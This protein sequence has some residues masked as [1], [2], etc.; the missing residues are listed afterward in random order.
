MWKISRRCLAHVWKVS[1]SCL[2]VFEGFWKCL[3]CC[4]TQDQLAISTWVEIL[5][6]LIIKVGLW[7]WLIIG[8]ISNQ[9]P[10]HPLTTPPNFKI[11]KEDFKSRLGYKEP[12]RACKRCLV[13]VLTVSERCLKG[14]WKVSEKC[15]E[16]VWKVY[17]V[18]TDIV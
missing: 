6:V 5:L 16:D 11:F 3:G 14:V 10:T 12:S 8:V 18:Y 4:H 2:K 1:L 17:A 9:P 13:C 7:I 15:Q